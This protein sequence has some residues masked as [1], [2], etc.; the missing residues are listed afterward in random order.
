MGGARVPSVPAEGVDPAVS[1]ADELVA[2]ALRVLGRTVDQSDVHPIT[3]GGS[4]SSVHRIVVAEGAAVLKITVHRGAAPAHARTEIALYRELAGRLPIRVPGLLGAGTT[5]ELNALLLTAAEPPPPP[6]SWT[7]HD[8]LRL[9]RELGTLHAAIPLGELA[10]LRWLAADAAD[11]DLGAVPRLR[12][13]WAATPVASSALPVLDRLPA[14]RTHVERAPG[15]LVHG[16][17]H[18]D[19]ILVDRDGAFVWIDWQGV[20]AGHGVEDLALLWQRAE[21]LGGTPPR[22][23][24]LAAYGDARGL[25][26]DATLVAA[27]AAH[28]LEL[29]LVAW[30]EHLARGS[31]AG[32]AALLDRLPALADAV[33]PPAQ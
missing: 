3:V 23:A 29:L 8:W 27:L 13:W 17:C 4:G 31:P 12:S 2:R 14:L 7:D 16:D 28:E 9:A 25:R 5:P 6:A 22:A 11:V 26:M 30:P 21:F 20:R 32:R 15:C 33:V 18:V 24:M 10:S 19:N 1:D